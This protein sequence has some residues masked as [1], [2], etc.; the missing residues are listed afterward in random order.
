[1]KGCMQTATN[2]FLTT[3]VRFIYSTKMFRVDEIT[4]DRVYEAFSKTPEST[5]ALDGWSPKEL[6]ML[7]KQACHYVAILLRQVEKGA[8]W[9]KST[10]HARVTFLEKVGAAIGKVTSYRP[11]TITSPLIRCYGSMRLADLQPWIAAWATEDMFA[12]VPG[13]GAVDAWYGAL[14]TLSLIH[15]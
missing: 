12:G 8:P 4:G 5:A 13:K 7:S 6:S 2:I 3:Y 1:M 11:L 15:I 10:M 14:T 9:P